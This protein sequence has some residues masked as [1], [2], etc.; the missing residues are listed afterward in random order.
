MSNDFIFKINDFSNNKRKNTKIYSFFK[1]EIDS[2]NITQENIIVEKTDDL[3]HNIS[4][5]N[6][7]QDN[8]FGKFEKEEEIIIVKKKQAE[9]ETNK[10]KNSEEIPLDIFDSFADGPIELDF[11]D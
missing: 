3:I 8:I 2:F 10:N 11:E 4:K 6:I 7:E 1:K 5:S 9:I